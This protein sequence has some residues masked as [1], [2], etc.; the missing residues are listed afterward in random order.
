MQRRLGD[1]QAATTNRDHRFCFQ[2]VAMTIKQ[3][4]NQGNALIRRH[5][6]ETHQS[7]MRHPLYVDQLPE[8]GIQRHQDSAVFL[9]TFEQCTVS[10]ID[11]KVAAIEHVVALVTQPRR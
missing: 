11:A 1:A 7:R 3:F 6:R 2:R 8:I 4:G 5:I 10:W 9:G